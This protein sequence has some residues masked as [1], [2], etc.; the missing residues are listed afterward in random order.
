MKRLDFYPDRYYAINVSGGRTSGYMLRKIL[1]HCGGVLPDNVIAAFM[2][3]GKERDEALDFV[4]K[5]QHEWDVEIVWLEYR[6]N[7]TA[8]G[9]SRDPKNTFA[10]VDYETASRKG[11][12]FEQ[13]ILARSFLPNV[14]QRVCTQELKVNTLAR[15]M[16][17]RFNITSKQIINLIGIRRDERKRAHRIFERDCGV[18]M[19]LYENHIYLDDITEFWKN[20]QF[21]LQLPFHSRFSNCDLCFLKGRGMLI[22]NIKE[23]PERADWWMRME[24]GVVER[25]I[26]KF[27]KNVTVKELVSLA[28]QPGLFDDEEDQ[29]FSCFCGD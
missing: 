20:N 1:D 24:E 3:T 11:E 25:K 2:N 12:P 8:K 13:L 28:E 18:Q 17:K 7:T 5:M 29:G 14:F 15:Y 6:Y 16:R 23:E 19:P 21:D 22:Q 4:K 9:W 27:N 26:S 10:V